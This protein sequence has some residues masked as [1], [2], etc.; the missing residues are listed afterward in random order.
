MVF[1]N[2]LRGDELAFVVANILPAFVREL[3]WH[4]DSFLSRRQLVS[5]DLQPASGFLSLRRTTII[6]I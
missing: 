4:L 3:R 5:L 6:Q 2:P 1:Q